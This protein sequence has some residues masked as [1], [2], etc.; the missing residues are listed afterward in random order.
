MHKDLKPENV[1]MASPRKAPLGGRGVLMRLE[2]LWGQGIVAFLGSLLP[3]TWFQCA[4][5]QAAVQTAFVPSE[6]ISLD[7]NLL[8]SPRQG[9][10]EPRRPQT[11]NLEALNPPPKYNE[12]KQVKQIFLTM[13]GGL[14]GRTLSLSL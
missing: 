10:S 1:M 9:H 8:A 6:N 2:C 4:C 14:C 3:T 11:R 12:G 5:S 13:S 7:S